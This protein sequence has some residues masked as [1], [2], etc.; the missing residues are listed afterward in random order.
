VFIL[1]YLLFAG[2]RSYVAPLL[3]LPA[4]WSHYRRKRWTQRGVAAYAFILATVMVALLM[5]RVLVPLYLSGLPVHSQAFDDMSGRPLSTYLETPD[6]AMF[7]V[8]EGCVAEPDRVLATGGGWA[9]T[10]LRNVIGP[11][12]FIVPRPLWPE[13]PEFQDFGQIVYRALFGSDDRVGLAPG[14][15]GLLYVF[16]GIAGVLSGALGLGYAAGLLYSGLEPRRGDP[17]AVFVYGVGLWVLVTFLRFG[18][19]G[20]TAVNVIQRLGPGLIISASLIF[21]RRIVEPRAKGRTV[22]DRERSHAMPGALGV[23]TS[24]SPGQINRVGRRRG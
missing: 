5:F 23:G 6:L 21:G 13:K 18:S 24:T 7:D 17:G 10:L 8:V 20:F 19:I 1:Q 11:I 9:N 22:S 15:L 4:I 16:G 14:Y 2:K 3:V 12:L